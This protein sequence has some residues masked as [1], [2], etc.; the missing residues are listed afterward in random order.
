MLRNKGH[1]SGHTLWGSMTLGQ[2]SLATTRFQAAHAWAATAMPADGSL[3]PWDPSRPPSTNVH[4]ALPSTTRL[5]RPEFKHG[6]PFSS[7]SNFTHLV[8]PSGLT[9]GVRPHRQA[10]SLGDED[11]S[12]LLQAFQSQER[13][14]NRLPA[15]WPQT[16]GPGPVLSLAGVR[17]WTL[18]PCLRH[19]SL[20]NVL[21]PRSRS[22]PL[23]KA[24]TSLRSRRPRT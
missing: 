19:S 7:P 10:V 2:G 11:G 9:T 21:L 8:D 22:P 14:R 5:T 18:A 24:E 4:D 1:M 13:E 6:N 3:Q 12:R 20:T 15:E 16:L 23:L 17:G